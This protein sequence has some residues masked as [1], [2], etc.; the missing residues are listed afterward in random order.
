MYPYIIWVCQ[1]KTKTKLFP[2][3]GIACLGSILLE[4]I[5]YMQIKT[6][7]FS[8]QY[9]AKYLWK[10]LLLYIKPS[11]PTAYSTFDCLHLKE[12]WLWWER[13]NVMLA[14]SHFEWLQFNPIL[15]GGGGCLAPPLRFFAHDSERE[16]DNS[17]KFGDFS[18]K[19]IGIC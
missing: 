14:I 16:K 7:H 1:H 10:Y 5:K 4:V 8:R 15:P 3:F 2:Q 6:W 9:Y 19:Y 17:T 13:I 11:W 18:W 12:N